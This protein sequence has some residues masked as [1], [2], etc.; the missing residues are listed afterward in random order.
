MFETEVRSRGEW[1]LQI[2]Y[3]TQGGGKSKRYV[4]LHRG[5]EGVKNDRN[6]RYVIFGRPPTP[7]IFIRRMN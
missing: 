7:S 5:G 6:Q 1:G 3:V 4:S 2:R